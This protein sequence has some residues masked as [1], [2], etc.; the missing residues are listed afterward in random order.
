MQKEFYSVSEFASLLD[1]NRQTIQTAIRYGRIQAF[2]VGIGK[3]APYRIHFTE[4]E[5]IMKMGF[6]ETVNNIKQF[7]KEK[8]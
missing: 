8:E 6:D 4:I 2:R 7:I 5:R 3:R 1:V